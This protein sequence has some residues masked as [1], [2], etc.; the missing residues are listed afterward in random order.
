MKMVWHHRESSQQIPSICCDGLACVKQS[1]QKIKVADPVPAIDHQDQMK[2]VPVSATADLDRRVKVFA[3]PN[4]SE[5]LQLFREFR[6]AELCRV[7]L[8]I[9]VLLHISHGVIANRAE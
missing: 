1:P 2:E 3:L 5:L 9:D 7:H 6:A 4:A 8:A